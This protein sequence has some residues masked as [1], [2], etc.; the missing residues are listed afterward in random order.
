MKEIDVDKWY[1]INLPRPIETAVALWCLDTIGWGQEIEHKRNSTVLLDDNS[2][3]FF[4]IWYGHY[5]FYFETEAA[6]N[7]FALRFS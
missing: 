3:W 7:W 2:V 4:E 1:G 5:T 6:R